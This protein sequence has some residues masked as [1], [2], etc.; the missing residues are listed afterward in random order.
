MGMG[1]LFGMIKTKVVVIIAQ[2]LAYTKK[3][4]KSLTIL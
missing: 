4:W 3:Q 1:F 2:F